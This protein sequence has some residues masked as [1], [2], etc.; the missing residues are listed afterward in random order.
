M[1]G[2]P[3]ITAPPNRFDI[4]TASNLIT[5]ERDTTWTTPRLI[6]LN[7]AL[8]AVDPRLDDRDL[9]PSSTLT[10][11]TTTKAFWLAAGQLADVFEA[12]IG[13]WVDAP[14]DA[15]LAIW[16]ETLS[17]DCELTFPNEPGP[18]CGC[19]PGFVAS[20]PL[21]IGGHNFIAWINTLPETRKD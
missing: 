12:E 5:V 1:T 19:N 8:R 3:I 9:Y 6:P 18:R 16:T 21:R 20:R 2:A 14:G 15:D 13:R 7:P 17:A 11:H 10:S 4:R